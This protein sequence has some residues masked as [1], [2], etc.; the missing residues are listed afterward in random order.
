MRLRPDGYTPKHNPD[1]PPDSSDPAGP[2]PRCGRV[3][4]FSIEGTV[5]VTFAGGSY[6]IGPGGHQERID[7]QQAAVLECS[8]CHERIVVIEDKYVG[9][10]RAVEGFRGGGTINYR[11]VWWW[12]PP[13]VADLDA[14]IPDKIADAYREGIRAM[15]AQAP[16]AAAVMFRRTLEAI[17]KTSG[18]TTAQD[19]ATK[20]NLASGL[21]VMADEGALDRSLAEWAKEIR[22]VANV[23]AH[24]DP[25]DDVTPEEAENLSRL[26][27]EL[28]RYLY[29]MPAR[30][31][32]TRST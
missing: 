20:K 12:P 17:V 6:T 11:G 1:T 32:R 4:N 3:S 16:R 7:S 27:R 13:G 10:E 18:S 26:L 24:F 23:G 22:I 28:L 5:G 2:C 25:V 31:S 8:G 30:I 19:A 14:S 15:W 21:S 9:N 29:E